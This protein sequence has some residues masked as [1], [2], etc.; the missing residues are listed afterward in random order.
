MSDLQHLVGLVEDAVAS[1]PAVSRRTMFGCEGWFARDQVFALVWKEGRVGVKLVEAMAFDELMAQ[2]GADP[3]QPGGKM[4]M[5][6]WVLVPPA[7]HDDDE[8]LAAWLV[9][10]HAQALSAPPKKRAQKTGKPA[11]KKAPAKKAPAN[12]AAT[13]RAATPAKKTP[14]TAKA[15]NGRGA[16]PTGHRG[17]R[18]R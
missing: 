16:R 2:P 7:L 8:A 9:R 17:G 5:S 6:H 13:K 1:L 3:W 11:A 14:S 4:T 12:A 10:A 15:K 18:R